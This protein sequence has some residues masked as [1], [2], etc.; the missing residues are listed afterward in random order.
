MA[1]KIKW[2]LMLCINCLKTACM[3]LFWDITLWIMNWLLQ[4]KIRMCYDFHIS[5]ATQK[6]FAKLYMII[7]CISI[8]PVRCLYNTIKITETYKWKEWNRSIIEIQ[9][10]L[11][12]NFKKLTVCLKVKAHEDILFTGIWKAAKTKG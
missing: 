3:R 8:Q 5:D 1:F 6:T 9:I 10:N 7:K 12:E 4:E 11:Y 2:P